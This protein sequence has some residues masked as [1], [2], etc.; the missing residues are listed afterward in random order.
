MGMFGRERFWHHF[1]DRSYSL[2]SAVALSI[3]ERSMSKIP[4]L[5]LPELP[6]SFSEIY[7]GARNV[8]RSSA[9]RATAGWSESGRSVDTPLIFIRNLCSITTLDAGQ[10]FPSGLID[11]FYI[12]ARSVKWSSMDSMEVLDTSMMDCREVVIINR[13]SRPGWFKH[14][15]IRISRCIWHSSNFAM[16]WLAYFRSWPRTVVQIHSWFCH[17]QQKLVW[18]I[19]SGGDTSNWLK[20]A[21]DIQHS[22]TIHDQLCVAFCNTFSWGV[23]QMHPSV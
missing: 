20:W 16:P 7:V 22:N 1:S 17:D 19:L 12:T 8:V 21:L 4:S 13:G 10:L 6:C 14:P 2:S 18:T 11:R 5:F 15:G 3:E 9:S 23:S